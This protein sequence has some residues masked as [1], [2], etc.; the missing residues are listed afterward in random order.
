MSGSG[1][2]VDE[3]YIFDFYRTIVSFHKGICS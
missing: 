1:K 3:C 2:M